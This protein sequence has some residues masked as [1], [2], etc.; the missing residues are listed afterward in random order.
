MGFR[1]NID[2]SIRS[3]SGSVILQGENSITGNVDARD[4]VIVRFLTEVNGN[5][6]ATNGN[7]V[8]E[9]QNDVSGAIFS[10][11]D[12]ILRFRSDVEGRSPVTVALC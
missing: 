3:T 10:G 1:T 5:L 11:G 4:N 12:T 8:L 9:G 2:G 6:N 7:V